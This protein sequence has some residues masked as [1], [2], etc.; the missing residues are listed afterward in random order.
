[1]TIRRLRDYPSPEELAA[2]YAVPHDAGR[3]PDHHLRVAATIQLA[4][5]MCD[6]RTVGLPRVYTGADLSCGNG[7][8]LRA[9]E[10]DV[11]AKHYGD[12]APGWDYHGPIEETIDQIPEVGIFICSETIEHLADPS[13]VLMQVR[14]KAQRL[15]LST[16]ID[17]QYPS[18]NPEHVWGWDHEGVND[19]ITGAGWRAMTRVDVIFPDWIYDYQIWGCVRA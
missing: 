10:L 5:W 18:G 8:I 19:L 17:E 9:L 4:H 3:W 6:N 11:N 15:V 2:I 12:F 13:Q 14:E 7:D 1:M 16:P